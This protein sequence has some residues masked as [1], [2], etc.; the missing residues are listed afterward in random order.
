MKDGPIT[1]LDKRNTD[2]TRENAKNAKNA[3]ISKI[4][5]VL[6]LKAIFSK[7]TYVCTCV[8]NFK[9]LA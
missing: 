6:V 4:K 9:L 1:K 5:G 3:D 8:P 2:L 7:T